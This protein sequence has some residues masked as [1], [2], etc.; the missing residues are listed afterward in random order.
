M[1]VLLTLLLLG[2]ARSAI[3]SDAEIAAGIEAQLRALLHPAVL[4]VAVHRRSPFTTTFERVD[5]SMSGLSLD[6][7]PSSSAPAPVATPVVS[8][9][10]APAAQAPEGAQIRILAVH[11]ECHD[12]TAKQMLVTSMVWDAQDLRLPLEALRHHQFAISA[13]QSVAGYVL[14]PQE[15]LTAYLR[16]VRSPLKSPEVTIT[17][18]GCRITGT[19]RLLVGM[20]VRLQGQITVHG[21]AVLYFE[22]PRLKVSLFQVPASTTRQLLK[23]IN[24]LIDLNAGLSLPAPLAITRVTHQIGV[25]RLDAALKFPQPE[26]N[27]VRANP[28]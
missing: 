21:D 23:D 22:H 19:A 16:S 8:T 20:P 3:P 27:Y 25:L 9:A 18:D 6:Q 2:A 13:A 11:I 24:P 26:P 5:I 10:P 1:A 28:N 4:H 12:I 17:P 15:S 7:L 14:I